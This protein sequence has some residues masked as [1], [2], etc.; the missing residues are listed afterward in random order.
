M[1]PAPLLAR[2]LGPAAWARL[3]PAVRD[4]HDVSAPRRFAGRVDVVRGARRPARIACALFGLPPAGIDQPLSLA[5]RPDGAGELWER[6]FGSR[7]FA[8]RQRPAGPMRTAE[9]VGVAS[10]VQALRVEDGAL[11]QSTA[12]FRVLGVPLPRGLRPM[13]TARETGADGVYRFDVAIDLPAF[14]RLVA[15]RGW[16]AP[17]ACPQGS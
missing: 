17:E 16:L 9:R 10:A 11:L 1:T 15:Y 14:G 12:G 7:R 4:L 8:T 3:A 6:R 2:A 13:A 5:I